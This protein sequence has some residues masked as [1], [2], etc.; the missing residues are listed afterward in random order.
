MP[1]IIGIVSTT[2]GAGTTFFSANLAAWAAQHIN[3]TILTET[4]QG[5]ILGAL[6][7][8]EKALNFLFTPFNKDDLNLEE[9]ALKTSYGLTV[10]P[11]LSGLQD[12][13]FEPDKLLEA[14]NSKYTLIIIDLGNDPNRQDTKA[15]INACNYIYLIA[16]PTLECVETL[17]RYFKTI[18]HQ[19]NKFKLV[20]NKASPQ[21]YYRPRDV[22]RYLD[23]EKFTTIPFEPKH[24][25]KA[26]KKRLPLVFYGKGKACTAIRRL[27]AQDVN[28]LNEKITFNR[29]S[30]A[31]HL[32]YQ[33]EDQV[34][35]DC[36]LSTMDLIDKKA[37]VDHLTGC[38]NRAAL[39][40][41]LAEQDGIF[42][43]LFCDLDNF[44]M[45][46]D[47]YGHAAGD[48]ILRAF[49]DF[50]LK[51]TRRS[52]YVIRYGGDEFVVV[53]PETEI[54]GALNLAEKMCN[55]WNRKNFACIDNK[56]V[57]YSGG[58][59][60]IGIHGNTPLAVIKAADEA[61]YRV[62]RSGRGRVESASI[63]KNMLHKKITIPEDPLVAVC[64]GGTYAIMSLVKSKVKKPLTIIDADL[65][66]AS[67]AFM[68][69][70]NPNRIW[71]HDWRLGLAATPAKISKKVRYY[72][73]DKELEETLEERDVR[74]LKEIINAQRD[75]KIKVIVNLGARQDLLQHLSD[76][77]F[78]ILQ[79]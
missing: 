47:T 59:A 52:D 24:I 65:E 50:L 67:L 21:A 2:G 8:R 64:N 30:F 68:L 58:V 23:F 46:N 10:L 63:V 51:S 43:V 56:N 26:Q 6:F 29:V 19:W 14:L 75:Q 16:I 76:M 78:K 3:K 72:G 33:R 40:K 35:N 71:Q 48:E 38:L 25:N 13:K 44:K 60:Q 62:K 12:K 32:A 77:D 4:R 79:V 5:D 11:G 37:D 73:M 27:A 55:E 28:L 41:Y 15:I 22:A 66:N 17:S 39:E 49:G 57:L 34:Q 61:L 70:V 20:I 7:M 74:C 9:I 42:S 53:L 18:E 54:A 69:G 45:I 36:S 1:K 31:N